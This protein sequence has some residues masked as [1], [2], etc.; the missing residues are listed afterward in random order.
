M[1]FFPL[2]G[3]FYGFSDGLPQFGHRDLAGALLNLANEGEELS[4]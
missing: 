2:L 1:A 3:G 4:A